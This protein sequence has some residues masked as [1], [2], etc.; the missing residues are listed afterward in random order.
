MTSVDRIWDQA[1]HSAFT[2]LL[3]IE[4]RLYCAFREGDDHV[5]GMDGRI[6]IIMRRGEGAWRSLALLAEEGVDL[7][8]P[9][10]AQMPDG[11]IMVTCGGSFYEGS[12]LLKAETRT[13]F[14]DEEGR[15]FGPPEIAV[16]DER[17]RSN[18]D[19]L[20]RVT[21][22]EGVGY[23]V[24]YQPRREGSP[25]HLVR[26]LD[27]IHYAWICRMPLEG[28]PN[29]TTL[30]FRGNGEMVALVRREGGDHTACLGVASPPYTDWSFSPL[31]E[32]IGGPNLLA[33]DDE[34]WVLA[35][36]RYLPNGART[37]L[38]QRGPG[39]A[40]AVLEVLP[41]GGDTSYPGLVL[42]GRTLLVS[43]Y[44][45]HEDRTSIYL[46]TL[47]LKPSPDKEE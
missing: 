18:V 30:R 23:G 45:S 43:Y 7:R 26:T 27:G 39:N 25:I 35:G 14:S 37:A 8:D 47:E 1:P 10:L 9:K 4:D 19:W 31:P 11:R 28:N 15:A 5:G 29:E 22:H 20:W 33:L 40:W 41:S 12:T 6:R 2:D 17:M 32:P 36:R 16:I 44:S 21:W 46:A 13:F 24:V 3:K 42:D 34:T 38:F